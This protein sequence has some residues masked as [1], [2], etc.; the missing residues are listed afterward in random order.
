M[1]GNLQH[2]EMWSSKDHKSSEQIER[3]SRAASSKCAPIGVDEEFGVGIFNGSSGKKYHTSLIE[4]ECIDFQKRKL[5]CKHMYRLAHEL[6]L[7]HINVDSSK[8]IE[9]AVVLNTMN[10]LSDEAQKLLMNLL[11]SFIYHPSTL[12]LIIDRDVKAEELLASG[13]VN[14]LKDIN[15]GLKRKSIAILLSYLNEEDKKYL[16]KAK[17]DS[18]ISW[19]ISNKPEIALEIS[20]ATIIL[21]MNQDIKEHRNYLYK[22]LINKYRTKDEE[23]N[24]WE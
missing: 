4:C 3:K 5:P 6:K 22:I 19:I 2:W 16:K 17:K 23:D 10:S 14:E 18:I 12:P 9:K 7:L 8:H 1:D 11:Y 24:W 20:N 13:L 21:N 15:I